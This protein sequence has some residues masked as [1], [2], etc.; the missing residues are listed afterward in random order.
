MSPVNRLLDEI[1]GR[2]LWQ[3]L[4]LYMAGGWVSLEV[5]ATF[6]EQLLLPNWV[7]RGALI[8]LIVGLPIVLATAFFQRGIGSKPADVATGVHALFTWRKALKGGVLAFALLGLGAGGYLASRALGVGPA[9]TLVA[10]GRLEKREP[11]ILAD[12]DGSDL[13]LASSATEV[14][15]IDLASSD[16]VALRSP[17]ALRGALERMQRDPGDRLEFDIA[18][19]V[20]IREGIKGVIRGSI[21]SAGRGFV[22][23]VQLI[24]SQDGE[25]LISERETAADSGGVIAAID[26]LS[27]RLRARLGESLRSIRASPSLERRT[28]PSLEALQKLAAGIRAEDAG[29]HT[30]ALA[31]YEDAVRIDTTFASA[32]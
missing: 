9:A 28:T 31:L 32:P 15:R 27:E 6:V 4:G 26:K 19:Q 14:L 17:S 10:Q 24:S 25:A 5:V 30:A 16:A 11:L 13:D 20:A 7:F 12:F 1:H 3:V 23:S 22:I 21:G 8:L 2:S 29:D 18:R